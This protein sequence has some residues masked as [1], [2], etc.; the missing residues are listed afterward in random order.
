MNASIITAILAGLPGLI[1]AIGALFLHNK[2]AKKITNL[3]ETV[4]QQQ[5][6]TPRGV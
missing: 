6:R 4:R 3:H 5:V 2:N 1:T